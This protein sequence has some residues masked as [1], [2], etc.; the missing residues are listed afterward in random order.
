MCVLRKMTLWTLNPFE[1]CFDF[2]RYTHSHG[3]NLFQF[4]AGAELERVQI[5]NRREYK[6]NAIH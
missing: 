2:M 5:L 1:C 3:I 6:L 4:L